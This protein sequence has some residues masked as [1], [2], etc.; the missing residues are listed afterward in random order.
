MDKRTAEKLV[1]AIRL[2]EEPVNQLTEIT[3]KME[4]TEEAKKIRRYVGEIMCLATMDLL[5]FVVQQH[6]ELDPY[7]DYFKK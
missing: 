1:A 2:F 4:D 5:K 7:K 3:L 6:P